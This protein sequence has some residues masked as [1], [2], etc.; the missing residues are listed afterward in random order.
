[1][2]RE[3]NENSVEVGNK[4]LADGHLGLHFQNCKTGFWP[5]RCVQTKFCH[6]VSYHEMVINKSSNMC[7]V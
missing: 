6:R 4:M 5:A 3:P 1:M 7:K 2:S